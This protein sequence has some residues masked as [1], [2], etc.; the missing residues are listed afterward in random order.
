MTPQGGPH[1]AGPMSGYPPN[2]S[3]MGGPSPAGRGY[4]NYGPPNSAGMP[5]QGYGSMPSSAGG[6][7]RNDHMQ[8]G[9]GTPQ[10]AGGYASAGQGGNNYNYQP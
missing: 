10:S 1:S 9:Y 5:P 8:G 7:N 2:Q 4:G 3:P 6:F